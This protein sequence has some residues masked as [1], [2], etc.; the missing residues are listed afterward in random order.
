MNSGNEVDDDQCFCDMVERR[1]AFNLFSSRGQ[2]EVLSQV[3]TIANLQYAAR[4]IWTLCRTWVLVFIEWSCVVVI[5]T[6]PRRH[7]SVTVTDRE[8]FWCVCVCV[9]VRACVRVCVCVCVCVSVCQLAIV[10]TF[11]VSNL[12]LT[13]MIS[14]I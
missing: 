8:I 2:S 6:K 11:L 7:E 5:T 9:C 13:E 1:K 10:S 3:P 4:R 14:D 12:S